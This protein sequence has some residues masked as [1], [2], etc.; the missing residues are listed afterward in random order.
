MILGDR[1]MK[2]TLCMFPSSNHGLLE[3]P[4]ASLDLDKV[5]RPLQR[6]VTTKSSTTAMHILLFAL[7]SSYLMCTGLALVCKEKNTNHQGCTHRYGSNRQRPSGRVSVFPATTTLTPSN[8]G[9]QNT[10]ISTQKAPATMCYCAYISSLAMNTHTRTARHHTRVRPESYRRRAASTACGSIRQAGVDAEGEDHQID[11]KRREA[12]AP[13]AFRDPYVGEDGGGQDQASSHSRGK[14]AGRN[15][16]TGRGGR[17]LGRGNVGDRGQ[18]TGA[19]PMSGHRGRAENRLGRPAA[20]SSSSTEGVLT[21]DDPGVARTGGID[22]EDPLVKAWHSAKVL[23]PS[24][25]EFPLGAR[26]GTSSRTRESYGGVR[27]RD[28]ETGRRYSQDPVRDR[29]LGRAKSFVKPDDERRKGRQGRARED[30]NAMRIGMYK[31]GDSVPWYIKEVQV[32]SIRI[33]GT[34]VYLG[35]DTRCSENDHATKAPKGLYPLGLSSSSA[36]SWAAR[37]M[38]NPSAYHV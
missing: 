36:V 24:R 28:Q 1:K 6:R 2:Y 18:P 21:R 38:R 33:R 10:G 15:G 7:A 4:S 37:Q 8:L 27:G 30:K 20:A 29:S 3:T 31:A 5:V 9:S 14:G 11:R 34:Q 17:T 26:R 22:Q 35:E 13:R 25:D 19:R 16:S 12:S 23:D 32:T